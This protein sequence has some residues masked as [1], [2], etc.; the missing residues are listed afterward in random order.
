M[1]ENIFLFAT[2]HA[3]Q[4]NHFMARKGSR[5]NIRK[6]ENLSVLCYLNCD[7]ELKISIFQIYV[8]LMFYSLFVKF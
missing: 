7:I 1:Q 3:E 8:S 2:F 6:P 4:Y 5:L